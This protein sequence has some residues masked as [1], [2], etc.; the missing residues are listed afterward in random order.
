MIT[1]NR[2]LV[3]G[4]NVPPNL[5]PVN[6]IWTSAHEPQDLFQFTPNHFV[7]L[8][9]M[10]NARTVQPVPCLHIPRLSSTDQNIHDVH[11]NSS[12]EEP[13]SAGDV[14]NDV[15]DPEARSDEFNRPAQGVMEVA[16][17]RTAGLVAT[18]SQKPPQTKGRFLHLLQ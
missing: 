11:D 15:Q 6:I 3:V 16:N 14:V 10:E 18:Q 1:L 17:Q 9:P 12:A 7:V 13:S 2:W 4:R 8:H 5:P